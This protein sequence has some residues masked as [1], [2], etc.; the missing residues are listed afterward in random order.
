MVGA[1]VDVDAS[2]GPRGR[3]VHAVWATTSAI[4]S[5]PRSP[6]RA[7]GQTRSGGLRPRGPPTPPLAGAPLSRSAPAGAPVARL[8]RLCGSKRVQNSRFERHNRLT[9][10]AL[11]EPIAKA[12]RRDD[13]EH[14]PR[15]VAALFHVESG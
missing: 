10:L 11:T 2:T 15:D 6:A 5:I 3:L 13:V 1:G 8:S 9:C 7:R 14:L 12:V 4:A